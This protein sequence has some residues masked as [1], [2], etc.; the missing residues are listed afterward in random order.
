M[1]RGWVRIHRKIDENPLWFSEK[2]TRGQAWVDLVMI[3]CHKPTSIFVRGIEIK[4]GRGEFCWSEERLG[5]RWGWSRPKVSKFLTF[6][7][8]RGQLCRKRYNRITVN[9][10]VNYQKYQDKGVDTLPKTLRQKYDKPYV[11]N[12]DKNVKNV[13]YIYK[14]KFK[15]FKGLT[16]IREI[17]SDKT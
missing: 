11:Y 16:P 12:N 3:A 10:L 4:L 5:K 15:K 9:T 17:L 2:F 6:L 13:K 7:D 1:N 14:G 8:T